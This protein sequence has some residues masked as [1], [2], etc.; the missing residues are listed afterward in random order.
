MLFIATILPTGSDNA[1]GVDEEELTADALWETVTD[2]PDT[3]TWH[4]NVHVTC[5][6]PESETARKAASEQMW[7][8][9]LLT[10]ALADQTRALTRCSPTLRQRACR[11]SHDRVAPV[12]DAATR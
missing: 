11:R 4:E 10:T 9:G 12:I 2:K 1:G 3:H 7:L 8:A 5:R 6:S